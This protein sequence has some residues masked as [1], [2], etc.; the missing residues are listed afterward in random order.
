MHVLTGT[1]GYSYKEWKGRFYP[2]KM[3]EAEMLGFYAGRFPTVEINNTFYRM[4][5]PDM[6]RKW[7]AQTPDTFT[8]V[9]K[10]PQRITHH[11]RLADVSGDVA[12]FYETASALGTI[13][14]DPFRARRQEGHA[15]ISGG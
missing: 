4:P 9:L 8:F 12:Y 7:L 10:A 11:R 1:S 14:S 6:L 3:K 2:E 5:A 13:S 15:A